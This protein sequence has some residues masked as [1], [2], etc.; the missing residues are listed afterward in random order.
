MPRRLIAAALTAGLSITLIV[1]S[2]MPALAKG[3]TQARITGP[4]LDRAIVISGAGEP[5]QQS[6]LATLA[7]QT[8][9]FTV[10]FGAIPNMPALTPLRSAPPSASLGP[11]YTVIFTVPGLTRPS[12]MDGQIRQELYPAAGGGPVIYT[13]PGQP[14]WVGHKESVW[15]RGS[16]RLL[17]F[18]GRLGVPAAAPPQAGKAVATHRARKAMPPA[19]RASRVAAGGVATW[20]I[21]TMAIIAATTLAGCVLVLR[22]RGP[23]ASRG[24]RAQVQ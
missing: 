20:L 8:G 4:G 15:L 3:P 24:G 14:S 9:L 17:S 10:L 5:G 16:P 6:R 19:P 22:R 7:E 2:A 12:Q 1:I 11:K 18:L 13:P 21:A 23:T